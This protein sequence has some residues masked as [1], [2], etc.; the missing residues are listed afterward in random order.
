M[1][2]FYLFYGNTHYASGGVGDWEPQVF[3]TPDEA[4]AAFARMLEAE[5][6][7][8]PE[9]TDWILGIYWA[10]IVELMP[11]YTL[12]LAAQWN[13]AHNGVDGPNGNAILRV[14]RD[15]NQWRFVDEA[16]D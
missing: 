16:T 12:R 4:M 2:T 15:D 14:G 6:E 10:Q 3:T 9:P 8:D 11:D 5:Y 13:C 7:D 1:P